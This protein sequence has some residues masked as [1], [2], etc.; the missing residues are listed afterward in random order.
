MLMRKARMATAAAARIVVA[1]VYCTAAAFGVWWPLDQILGRSVPAQIVSVGLALSA[2]RAVYLAA[3]RIPP[4]PAP[5]V[6]GPHG[7]RLRG[8]PAPDT[9]PHC[10]LFPRA[11]PGPVGPHPRAVLGRR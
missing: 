10:L 3:G 11:A 7:H 2:G 9:V 6:L 8:R 5:A 4:P 1:T